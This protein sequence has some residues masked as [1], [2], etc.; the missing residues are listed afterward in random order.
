MV[1]LI[2][3]ATHP[4][5]T[6]PSIHPPTPHPLTHSYIQSESHSVISDFLWPPWTVA[7]QAPVC[8]ILQARILEWVAIPFSRGSSQTR[9]WTQVSCITGGSITSW[10]TT[11]AM[12]MNMGKLWKMVRDREAQRAAAH[13][14][15]KDQTRLGDW[16]MTTTSY[17]T[18]LI[19][20]SIAV[21]TFIVGYFMWMFNIFQKLKNVMSI[22][23]IINWKYFNI[24]PFIKKFEPTSWVNF[25][26]VWNIYAHLRHVLENFHISVIFN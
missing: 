7:F 14:V 18:N 5:I 17:W 1:S 19:S 12:D 6:S 26:V 16:M 22:L 8:G 15:T 3:R 11:E 10:T 23:N 21:I 9:D 13:G 4:P 20:N 24:F 25:R 2:Y